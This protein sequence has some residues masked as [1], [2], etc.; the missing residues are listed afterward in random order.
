MSARASLLTALCLCGPLVASDAK[1]PYHVRIVVHAEKNQLLTK[2]FR[3]QIQRELKDGVQAGLGALARV[4]VTD[5]HPLLAE[6][7]N[8]GQGKP[9]ATNKITNERTFFVLIDF[10]GTHYQVQTRLYDG[11]TGLWSPVVRTGRTQDRAYVARAAAF[12][13]QRDISLLGTVSSEPDKA[14]QVRLDL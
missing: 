13:M 9:G 14:Q 11:L 1:E 5:K 4:E 3:D 6:V 7:H 8:P 12:L 10:S 2:V